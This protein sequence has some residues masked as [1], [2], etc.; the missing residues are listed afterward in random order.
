MLDWLHPRKRPV[1]TDG[2]ISTLLGEVRV[3]GMLNYL[4]GL[5]TITPAF[6][7]ARMMLCK[8]TSSRRPSRLS[9][10]KKYRA[11]RHSWRACRFVH[12]QNFSPRNS[13]SQA[14]FSTWSPSW[15]CR[16]L[17]TTQQCYALPLLSIF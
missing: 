16:Q 13:N 12:Q 5:Q 10:C 17:A 2:F 7:R 9:A 3:S 11:T 6:C 8:S 1:A 14:A 15:L 4:L